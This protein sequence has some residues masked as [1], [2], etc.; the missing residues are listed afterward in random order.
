MNNEFYLRA[1]ECHW[2]VVAHTSDRPTVQL[3]RLTA[4]IRLYY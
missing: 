1:S 4:E 3:D 2:S